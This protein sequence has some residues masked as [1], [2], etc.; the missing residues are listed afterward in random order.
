MVVD[1]DEHPSAA[2]S[3]ETLA[4]P[5]P[6]PLVSDAEATVTAGNASGQNDPAAV[7][8]V[9]RTRRA[10]GPPGRLFA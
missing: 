6:V 4:K 8:P 7:C 9:T 2:T 10:M 5:K 3:V 1:T